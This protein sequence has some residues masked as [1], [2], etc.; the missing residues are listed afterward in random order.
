MNKE[1]LLLLFAWQ[2]WTVFYSRTSLCLLH[3][4]YSTL[5]PGQCSP[6]VHA[7]LLLLSTLQDWTVF[8]SRTCPCLSW[9]ASQVSVSSCSLTWTL[10]NWGCSRSAIRRCFCRRS[11][12]SAT[13]YDTYFSPSSWSVSDFVNCT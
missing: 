9:L 10:R 2:D 13:W 5:R 7:R 1:H 6:A 4:F 8:S 12:S 3:C 11:T